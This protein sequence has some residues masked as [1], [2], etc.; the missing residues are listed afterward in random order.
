MDNAA[1]SYAVSVSPNGLVSW[2]GSFFLSTGSGL[3]LGEYRLVLNDGRSAH[4]LVTSV[5]GRSSGLSIVQFKG[6]GPQPK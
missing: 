4:I 3:G 6:K 5:Q 1:G 2:S